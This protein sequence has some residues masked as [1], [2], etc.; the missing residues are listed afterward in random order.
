MYCTMLYCT[1]FSVVSLLLTVRPIVTCSSRVSRTRPHHTLPLF[2]IYMV[3]F[4]VFLN[5]FLN[6]IFTLENQIQTN[7]FENS[8]LQIFSCVAGFISQIILC[9]ADTK[10]IFIIGLVFLAIANS[11]ISS[12]KQLVWIDLLQLQNLPKMMMVES[13]L[14]G[15]LAVSG[16]LKIN[17][18]TL[19]IFSSIYLKSI[20]K[21]LKSAYNGLIFGCYT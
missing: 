6:N 12:F 8:T 11:G 4:W 16:M 5:K 14:S 2:K 15:I 19:R 21:R 1:R 13:I 20:F 18:Q 17:F 10:I 3:Q 7:S 9:F